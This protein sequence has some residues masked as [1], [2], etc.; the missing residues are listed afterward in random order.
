MVAKK[1]LKTIGKGLSFLGIFLVFL[2]LTLYLTVQLFVNGPSSS[3]RE[4]FVTTILET[5]QLKFLAS[6][7]LNE[8]EINEIVSKN[9]L[10]DLNS[11]VDTDLI[12]IPVGN[13]EQDKELI[14]VHDIV[15]NNFAG[16]MMVINDPSKVSIATTY[17]WGEYGEELDKLVK[18]NNAIAGIN[19][20]LYQSDANKGGRPLG[21]TVSH[22]EI[23][24]ISLGYKGL[25]LIGFDT[26]N[27]LRII[28]IDGKNKS[29]VEKIVKEE[30]I[31]DAIAFQEEASDKNNHFVK[32]I[33]NGEK[34]EMNGLGSGANPRTAIGQRKDGSVLFLVTDGRGKN[35]HL[36][37]TASDLIEIM[38]SWG[39]INAANL[40]GGSSSTMYY[41]DSYLMTSVTFYYS[42]SSWRLPTAFVVKEGN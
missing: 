38:E 36:G 4:L 11:E 5:G 41:K 8:N 28:N 6:L 25:Y 30:H 26:D 17:P 37:A 40:D 23:Q 15:G 33:V 14:E 2:I 12:D 35:G 16:K 21:V 27:I 9:S 18:K 42:N 20:G 31:R 10:K 22:G 24:D 1:I 29:Q 39:A 34:R 32:L 19:G 7:V 13:F 3:A